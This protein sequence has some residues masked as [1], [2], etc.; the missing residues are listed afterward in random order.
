MSKALP[1]LAAGLLS[2]TG[3]SAA[4]LPAGR[5]A[6]ITLG[7][8]SGV[9]YY[10]AEPEGYRVVTTLGAGETTTPV[11]FIAVLQPGQKAIVS[12]PGAPGGRDMAVEIARV[13]DDV[14]IAQGRSDGHRVVRA[15]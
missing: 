5:G 1:I 4:E 12:V 9:A 7:D 15:H 6:S 3:I 14:H 10:T 13:G 11:R 2:A 8:V